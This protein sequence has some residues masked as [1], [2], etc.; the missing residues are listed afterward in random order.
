MP[1]Y[2]F[3]HPNREEYVELFFSMSEEKVYID[4]D[5]VEW[6][7]VFYA[8]NVNA[9]NRS[10]DPNKPIYDEKGNKMRVVPISDELVKSQGFDNA[11]DYIEWNNSMVDQ[12]KTP[13]HN[14]DLAHRQAADKT[15]QDQIKENQA[16]LKENNKK[17]SKN[18]KNFK[19]KHTISAQTNSDWKNSDSTKAYDT[20]AKTKTYKSIKVDGK[21]VSSP[22]KTK[23]K[24]K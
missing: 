23:K 18:Q 7:R 13:E 6:K 11:A 10:Y 21:T 22:K 3:K 16:K 14:I 12:N 9:T 5:G 19:A 17:F 20:H 8:P 15:L 1:S 24:S 4:E 2:D